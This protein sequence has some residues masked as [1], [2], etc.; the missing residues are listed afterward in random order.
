MNIINQ[1][2]NKKTNKIT[3]EA[4][5][6]I[7][8][9]N[10]GNYLF[11]SN[12]TETRYQGFFY[13]DNGSKKQ[14]VYKI[15][16]KISPTNTKALSEIKNSFFK[17]EK[18]YEDGLIESYFM[19]QN[20]NTLCVEFSKNTE[21][22]IT[23]DIRSPYDSRLM[24]RFYEIDTE[25]DCLVIKFVKRRDWQ[26]DHLGDKKEFSL[27]LAVKSDKESYEKIGE[28][29]AQHYAKD[30]ER[31]SYPWD[32]FVFRAFKMSFKKAVFSV[33]NSKKE[34]LSEAN[35]AFKNFDKLYKQT[36]DDYGDLVIPKI[37]DPEIK[38]A[39]LC[40][41]SSIKT[42]TLEKENTGAYA[43]IPWFFQFWNRD[44]AVALPQIYKINRKV[45]KEIILSQ[46]DTILKRSSF[47]KQRLPES[48]EETQSA[49]ALGILVRSCQ[50]IFSENKVDRLF[51]DEVVKKFEKI[52]PKLL[53]ERTQNEMAIS[54][55]GETWM[56]SLDR[57][58]LR[59]EIQA[60]RLALYKFLY[61]ETN[62][63]QYKILLEH[64]EREIVKNFFKDEI[65]WDSPE[66]AT[67]R[68]NVFLA[69]YLYPE[70][71]LKEKWEKCFDKIL[72]ELYLEWGGIASVSQVDGKFISRDSG[73]NSPSYHNGDS[74]YWINNLTALVLF[75]L[76][77]AKYSEY[78]NEIMEAST[79]EILYMGAIGHH[80]EISSAEKQESL[81]CEAQ[82]WSAAMYLEFFD[83]A[84]KE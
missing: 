38:M 81:G 43:G 48:A 42:M 17:V 83:R 19:P 15:I 61:S 30:Q 54:Y 27:F 24:G 57:S 50:Q 56:D 78:I 11:L 75:D 44:E 32:R 23:L 69:Y 71:M 7:L 3:G 26:E 1:Y 79:N 21:T 9:N 70:L 33:N 73:E 29:I 55:A 12:R 74:W 52:T 60:G 18:K 53:K 10:V 40:A 65:P 35:N 77:P 36:R 46:L 34:A 62:N 41:Q 22:E 2:K 5:D 51:K 47:P 49:D 4:A 45:A 59:I 72:P 39:H 8:G 37:T 58:G 82:L 80:S 84:L 68:P 14:E 6:L 13:A 63:D 76:N 20:L 28:F 16:D 66:D 25:E 31:G 64:L 67:V